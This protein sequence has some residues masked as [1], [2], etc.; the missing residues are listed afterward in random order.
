MKDRI[1]PEEKLLRLIRGQK[2]ETTSEETEGSRVNV[3]RRL[4]I[5]Q[6]SFIR[7]RRIIQV[8]ALF[9][10]FSA[11][12]YLVYVFVLPWYGYKEIDLPPH[13]EGIIS[14]YKGIQSEI[15]PYE[16]YLNGIR[17]RPLFNATQ[18]PPKTESLAGAIDANIV[19]DITLVG[20]I[21]GEKP[22]AVIEDNKTQKIFYL[23]KGQFLGDI[24]VE[25]IQEGKIIL[26]YQG[27]RFELYL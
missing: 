17:N 14:E 26:N 5:R 2:K 19:K 21:A 20:I 1:S 27:K 8:S 3:N 22:Q 24:Q 12:V 7:N 18:E 10:F 16:F 11:C 6:L 15:K 25:D 13:P 9:V 4:D 23:N